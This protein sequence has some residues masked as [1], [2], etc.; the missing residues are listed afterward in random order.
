MKNIVYILILLTNLTFGQTVKLTAPE[1]ENYAKSIDK[2]R[3]ENKL[4]KISF[5]NM[6]GCGGGVD[7][8][9]LNRNLV[10]IDATYNAELGFSSRT[11]YIDQD[12]F[13]KI[14]YREY[15]AEWG[16]Y[17]QNYPADKFEF[18]PKKMTYT[19]AI[20]SILLTSPT[21]F[22]KKVDNKIISNKLKQSLIDRLVSCG[23]EM[24]LELQEVI[25]QVDSLKFVKEMPYICE[26]EICG[27]K[28]YW[29]AVQLGNSGIELLIDKL[30]DTTSTTANVVLF[31]GNY[32]VAD[33]AFNALSEII[34]NFPTFELLGV[35][36]DK[37]GCGYCS[38]WQHLNKD[39]SNRQKF[40]K[41]VRIWYHQNKDN[42]VWV[43]GNDFATCDCRGQHPNGGHYKLK[44]DKK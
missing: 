21:V 36:F 22:H 29:E 7:G 38:Y 34:H 20:Y 35:P 37:D 32:T 5:P 4:V 33:I 10:L 13:L 16:K 39:F 8:Y 27:D 26:I 2:L 1:I 18:D 40:K 17:D 12:K 23:Q 31:G 6:S 24:K 43:K 30:D 28:L 15:F 44:T 41:A 42:L 3:A 9:Y 25:E 11:I 14:I 19:D